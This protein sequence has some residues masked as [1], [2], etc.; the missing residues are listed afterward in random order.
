MARAI[1]SQ[2][3]QSSRCPVLALL[4]YLVGLVQTR[5]PHVVL[6]LVPNIVL[7]RKQLGSLAFR[8]LGI[9]QVSMSLLY[10]CFVLSDES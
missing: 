4:A 9:E 3:V 2:P 1:R 8:I 7:L 6:E 5:Q 10:L